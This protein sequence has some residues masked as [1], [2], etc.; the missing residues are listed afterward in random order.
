MRTTEK[1]AITTT[2]KIYIESPRNT[3]GYLRRCNLKKP[4]LLLQL[5]IKYRI[6]Y[7]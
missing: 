2:L 1:S 7:S 4:L 5:S 6:G 3:K